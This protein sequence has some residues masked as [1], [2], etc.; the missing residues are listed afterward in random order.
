MTRRTNI[1]LLLGDGWAIT[2]SN[3]GGARN[4]HCDR[5]VDA[6]WTRH[7]RVAKKRF[8]PGFLFTFGSEL[9]NSTAGECWSGRKLKPR[10]GA[11]DANFEVARV[12]VHQ[13]VSGSGGV[14]FWI[15]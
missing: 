3:T 6:E 7:R 5:A 11:N 15:R 2:S 9:W 13:L 4:C 10:R 1:G 8:A 12:L 14:R